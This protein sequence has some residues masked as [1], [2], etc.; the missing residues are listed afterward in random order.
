MRV[1]G[2]KYAMEPGGIHGDDPRLP[3]LPLTPEGK[4]YI[5]DAVTK[6]G[7]L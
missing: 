4:R 7:L 5:R 2:V 1:A 6:A 3:L